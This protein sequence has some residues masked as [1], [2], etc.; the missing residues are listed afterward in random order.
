MLI[1][2]N[3]FATAGDKTFPP[4]NC[5]P[6]KLDKPWFGPHCKAA[7]TKY[8]K[9]RTRFHK[10][11]SHTNHSELI[12]SSR[13]YKKIMNSYIAKHE[14]Q[15]QN[16]LRDMESKRPRE[17]WKFINSLN[18]NGTNHPTPTIQEF[19]DHFKLLNSC[20]DDSEEIPDLENVQN[21]EILNTK[22]TQNEILSAIR[23]LNN[24]KAP[25]PDRILIEYIKTTS[26]LLLPLYEMFFNCILDTGHFPEQWSVGCIYPIYKNKG[27][28]TDAQNYRPI[29]ILSCLG[30][31]FTSILNSR[32]NDYLEESML[33]SE[34]QAGFRQQYST[35]DH[36][37]SLYALVEL[38]K[39]QEQKLFCCFVDFSSAFDSV[40]RIGLW[41]KLLLSGVNGKVLNVILSMYNDI[42][43]CVFSQG[44]TSPFFSSFS[45]VRQ[46]ENLS[47]I[48]FSIYLNDLEAFLGHNS[49]A[50]LTIDAQ[51]EDL[52]IFL[53]LLVLLYADDTVLLCSNAEDLQFTLNRFH[54]YCI[55]WKLKVN[56]KKTK[57]VIFGTRTPSEYQFSLGGEVVEITEKYKY[58]GVY[59]SQSRSFLNARKHFLEQSKKAM[60]LLFSRIRNLN[61]PVDLQIK[62]FDYTILPILTYSCE[63]IGFENTDMF[64]K[65]HLEFLRKITNSRKSTPGYMLYAELGRY[66]L[67]IY[68]KTR[69][70][71]YWNK[72]LLSKQSKISYLLYQALRTI[73]NK[74]PK[75]ICFIEKILTDVGRNDI[76][77]NQNLINSTGI[78]YFVKQV[79]HDQYLQSWSVDLNESS[80]GKN[81]ST[82]K[83]R[84]E[85]EHYL[86]VLPRN[87]YLTMARF[88]TCNFKLPIETGRWYDIDIEERKCDICQQNTLGDEFHYLLECE[89]F[90]NARKRLLPPCY[91][92]R[93]NMLKFQ[94]LLKCK[95]VSC[96][97]NLSKFMGIIMKQFA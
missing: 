25:G 27:D 68:I 24:G 83:D 15:T 59:F 9:A 5:K 33:L 47:P 30:K 36:V 82:F 8:H 45:G 31:V 71:G 97:E 92:E 65:V 37:F 19:Y 51:S 57:I 1:I 76:W 66:P 79:L 43:S 48:L 91:Y 17:Y 16:R 20:N 58:L 77:L 12:K 28:R 61:L 11:K 50:G 6:K 18:R 94:N 41:K 60:H 75:W 84:I 74:R 56:I 95:D 53:R 80:K 87:L 7:R 63:V 73:K 81:Y 14:I 55:A 69:M 13:E 3:L 85:L 49:T 35:T 96:L 62:L 46:G 23:K 88:R 22:I 67:H 93:P 4:R 90:C 72:L 86:K 64:E 52:G 54:D 78:K 34:N 2:S 21:N 26:Q 32:I 40:W 10:N 70:I 89:H 44:I 42:K 29:T 39:L 38:L